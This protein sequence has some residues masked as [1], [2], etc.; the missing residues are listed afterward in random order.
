MPYSKVENKDIHIFFHVIVYVFVFP[1]KFGDFVILL[2]CKIH[3]ALLYK[4]FS[5]LVG[6]YWDL[7]IYIQ[8]P[9]VFEKNYYSK[10]LKKCRRASGEVLCTGKKFLKDKWPTAQSISTSSLIKA[11]KQELITMQHSTKAHLRQLM[12]DRK[13]NGQVY[14]KAFSKLYACYELDQEKEYFR[15]VFT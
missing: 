4:N 5:E 10:G 11:F 13:L 6:F 2:L 12:F 8:F 1:E 15:A 9:Y 14:Y 7:N 3:S